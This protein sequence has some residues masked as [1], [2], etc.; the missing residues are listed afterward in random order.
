MTEPSP[1]PADGGAPVR[2]LAWLTRDRIL[3]AV[4]A[5][6]LLVFVL[7]AN[8]YFPLREWLVFTL[9]RHW[10]LAL[11]FSAA[12]LAAGLRVLDLIL[13]Q[14]PLLA[15]RL[16]LGFALGVLVF[17]LGVFLGG[18]AQLFGPIFF[19]AW[20]AVLLAWGGRRAFH[21]L[22]QAFRHLRRFGARLLLPRGLIEAGAALLLV[23]GLIAVYLLVMTPL[24]VGG[25]SYWYHLPIA[26]YY[27]VHGGIRPFTEGW[28]LG[29]YPQLASLLY[30]WAFQ[31]PGQ[32]HHHVALS[33]HIEWML[34]LATVAGVGTLARRLLGGRRI[35]YAA[36]AFFLF[37]GIFLYDASLI[38]GADHVHAFWAPALGL[39]LIRLGRRFGPREAVLAGTL[40][41]GPLLTKYQG[42][43]LLA[44]A[45]LL[46]V[47]LV[48]RSKRVRPALWFG[49][50][51]LVVTSPHWL[52]NL[53]F[54]GDPLYPLLHSFLP[55]HPFH[56][57]ADVLLAREYWNRQFV[58]TGSFWRN[59]WDTLVVLP[60]FSF[61]PHDWGFHGRRP[62]FGSLFTLL[63]PVLLFF[64][65]R[66]RLWLMIAG[67]HV[68][69]IVWFV[70]SHQDRFLQ[71]VLPWM[72]ACTAAMLV[73]AW[74]GR[75]LVR[76]GIALLVLFEIV[77]GGDVYFIRT[78]NMVGDS[79]LKELIN[80]VAAGQRGDYG[81]RRRLHGGS[82]RNVG[83]VVPPDAVVLIHDRHDRLGLGRKSVS[84][85]AGWQGTIDYLL[86]DTPNATLAAWRKL[87]ITHAMWWSDRGGMSPEELA[88]EAVFAR[89]IEQWGDDPQEVNE[90]RVSALITGQARD[91]VLAEQSTRLAWLGCGG[92]PKLAI[93]SAPGLAKR[94]PDRTLEEGQVHNA[95][96]DALTTVNAFVI[97]PSCDYLEGVE[98]QL[99]N[100]F[101]RAVKAGDVA[102]WI[103]K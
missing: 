21:E 18:L 55:S 30:T 48:V 80:F 65:G 72:A 19:F 23:L 95:P 90:R 27:V 44:P 6:G 20:P 64:H 82:L 25:D 84:D 46:V 33:S 96:L 56:P 53:I 86:L 3:A 68:S 67:C 10:L 61:V 70:T 12:S 47:L 9:L 101:K 1:T 76:W 87:G 40:T 14:P 45:A 98:D 54:Y 94:E 91:P 100:Q 8:A 63:I 103:R 75:T 29:A 81:D 97:R 38:T 93:Y 39:A 5:A 4:L 69:L 24:N 59:V 37:H 50:T 15:E 13:P 85:T 60:T 99:A 74:Q 71:A 31:A 78:H 62:V 42:I 49:M 22:R 51:L 77:W 32:L 43:L 88:R 79:P 102:L 83:E 73:L 36:A 7:T 26:E 41:A 16:T 11:L 66:R 35:P 17:A 57:G 58:L 92:D 52:K 89:T 2:R 34:F 28:Y